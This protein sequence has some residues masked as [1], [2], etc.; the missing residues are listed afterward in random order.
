LE[1]KTAI[2]NDFYLTS[3]RLE[4]LWFQ[5]MPARER[6]MPSFLIYINYITDLFAGAVNIKLFADRIKIYMEITDVSALP[7]FQKV[8]MILPL[9]LRR[10]SLSWQ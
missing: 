8:L 5:V 7:S 6:F 10:G 4:Q 9:G 1:E 2:F 3:E